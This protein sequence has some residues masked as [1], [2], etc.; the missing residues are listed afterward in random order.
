ML[1][2]EIGQ[3]RLELLPILRTAVRFDFGREPP[4]DEPVVQSVG[5]GLGVQ[6]VQLLGPAEAAEL[7]VEDQVVVGAQLEEV[8]GHDLHWRRRVSAL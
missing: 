5:D 1:D 8:R 2:V 3:E 6:P 4:V 7:I